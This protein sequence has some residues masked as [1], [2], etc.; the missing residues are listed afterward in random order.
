MCGV[1]VVCKKTYVCV[2]GL[3]VCGV[4]VY[5][6]VCVAGWSYHFVSLDL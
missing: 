1:Y 4:N 6:C 3:N 2:C 5:V